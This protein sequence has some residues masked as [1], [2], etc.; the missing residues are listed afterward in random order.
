MVYTIYVIFNVIY[1]V[2]IVGTLITDIFLHREISRRLK[3]MEQD[4]GI[5]LKQL[6]INHEEI[7]ELKRRRDRA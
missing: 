7:E 2:L 6:A 5:L 1:A 3:Q 4:K